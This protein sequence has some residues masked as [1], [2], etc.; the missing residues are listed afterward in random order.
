MTQE[1]A[2]FQSQ[3]SAP[4]I[5]PPA[6]ASLARG[7]E[8]MAR[9]FGSIA[10][11]ATVK[12]A[13]FANEASKASLLQTHGMLQDVDANSKIEMIKSPGQSQQIA[14]NADDAMK[15]I[16]STARLNGADRGQLNSMAD[17]LIRSL[18]VTAAERSFSL[19]REQS[20]D[21]YLVGFSHTL[22]S[23]NRAVF[24]NPDQADQLIEAQHAA[25]SG[26]VSSGILTALQAQVLH[27]QLDAQLG[28][29]HEL[30]IGMREGVLSASDAN[31]YHAADPIQTPFSNAGLPIAHDTAM[32]ANHYNG[33][34]TLKDIK[35]KIANGEHPSTMDLSGIKKISEVDSILNYGGGAARATGDINSATNWNE[36]KSKEKYLKNK[37]GK[38]SREEGYYHALSNFM[39][40]AS[41]PGAYQNF[42]SQTP[43]GARIY[44][45]H[46]QTQEAIN[47][48][49]PF[50]TP[51][52]VALQKHIKTTDNLN[53]LITKSAALGIGMQYP[54][55]LR[56][57]IP[58]QYLIP[59]QN[60][61][62]KGGDINGAINNIQM[63]SPS[64]RVYA[65]NAFGTDYRKKLTVYNIGTLAGTGK[66]SPGFMVDLMQSQQAGYL[67]SGEAKV[68]AQDKY[69]QLDTSKDGYSDKRLAGRI[70]PALSSFTNWLR[71]QPNGREVESAEI[72]KAMRYVKYVAANNG[73]YHMS[74]ID[75]YIKTYRDNMET[76]YGVK[77]GYNYILDSNSVH[78]EENQMQVLASHAMNEAHKNLSK[79]Y[80]E[81]QIQEI[82]VNS[83]PMLTSSPGG[84]IS[85]IYPNGQNVVG[86]SGEPVF[87]EIFTE[88]VWRLAEADQQAN[89]SSK[90]TAI[91]MLGKPVDTYLRVKTYSNR[92]E[93]EGNIDL[94]NRPKVFDDQGN[95]QTVKTITI[96]ED[97][98]TVLL[99][100]IVNGEAV[101]NKEAIDYYHAT[102]EHL[103]IFKDDES[104]QQYDKQL[105]TRMGM[106]GESNKWY[107]NQENIKVAQAEAE[108]QAQAAE[109]PAPKADVLPT[110][111]KVDVLPATPKVDVLPALK[112]NISDAVN[113]NIKAAASI[114]TA[115]SSLIGR[116]MP[117]K[118]TKQEVDSLV[119]KISDVFPSPSALNRQTDRETA[120]PIER[121]T[122]DAKVQAVDTLMEA[123][124]IKGIAGKSKDDITAAVDYLAMLEQ[125]NI[126]PSKKEIISQVNTI[127]E[128][129]KNK[130]DGL[131]LIGDVL[132]RQYTRQDTRE[133]ARQ[134]SREGEAILAPIF[135]EDK[136]VNKFIPEPIRPDLSEKENEH[137]FDDA[138][139][140][141]TAARKLTAN[142][143]DDEKDRLLDA[144]FKQKV[145][146]I[147]TIGNLKANPSDSD[148]QGVFKSIRKYYPDLKD[149]NDKELLRIVSLLTKVRRC[150]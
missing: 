26:Q 91:T 15:K 63:L 105:H 133:E 21:A 137:L 29:A 1:F 4:V 89:I 109:A 6:G 55:N 61:F 71:T 40:N 107:T 14:K 145:N 114:K 70:A 100:T 54:D 17:G 34:M 16:R 150:A 72:D 50:G 143:S 125:N 78:L 10:E 138:R 121:F 111:P 12:A 64:N 74:H 62:E 32:H 99:P 129:L 102:G 35:A 123:F 144:E 9:T 118:S 124:T 5:N 113:R 104:A 106:I 95:Y 97:G 3:D 131:N 94:E 57:P 139:G 37:L 120:R 115:I 58:L 83:T 132:G 53:N 47:Q 46:Q 116:V 44:Q 108:A 149:V 136:K 134:L 75:D 42:V 27:K 128:V 98:N 76:A 7:S 18:N 135:T 25:L 110:T 28:M 8:N 140:I 142:M 65:M 43:E 22:S 51:E 31:T 112:A 73:D 86:R 148:L 127:N 101:T 146:L 11:R 30:A 38:S 41:Q 66:A 24:S 23:I 93:V 147:E 88:S 77:S 48:S 126:T 68:S 96:E 67:D 85:L 81:T 84:R 122:H 13:D 80:T 90:R 45:D 2:R 92:P 119:N 69:L 130:T 60:A 19:M 117:E 20:K 103:G 36:L 56:Q 82:F 49:V 79:D 52:Q 141:S 87:N 39:N 33:Q 59:I